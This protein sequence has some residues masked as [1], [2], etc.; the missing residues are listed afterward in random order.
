MPA[1]ETVEFNVSCWDMRTFEGEK[2][3]RSDILKVAS[4]IRQNKDC[5]ISREDERLHKHRMGELDAVR[6]DLVWTMEE[7][8][9]GIHGVRYS[10]GLLADRIT[11]I[12]NACAGLLGF[13]DI[14]FWS[15]LNACDADVFNNTNPGG[16]L[17]KFGQTG[18]AI[19]VIAGERLVPD[20]RQ[21][22]GKKVAGFWE[23]KGTGAG[24]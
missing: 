24:R 14:A 5:D 11:S 8:N 3:S 22:T 19:N 20:L 2:A 10:C 12:A 18:I 6:E 9:K 16:Q 15:V 4:V 21:E 17:P 13:E 23:A 1:V 7:L